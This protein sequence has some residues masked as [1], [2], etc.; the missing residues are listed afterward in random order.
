MSTYI[1]GI[2]AYFHDSSVALVKDGELIAAVE[3]ERFSRKKHDTSFPLDAIQY[4]LEEAGITIQEVTHIAF[5]EKPF[6]KMERIL[7]QHMEMFPYS[8]KSFYK[9]V[10]SWVNEKIRVQKTI[11]KELKFAGEIFYIPHHLCHAASS[12]LIS[13]YNESAILTIDGVGEWA[14]TTIGMAKGNEIKL[15]K[16][17]KFPHSI[18][19]L[20]STI[21]AFL[22]FKVN[23]G[24]YKAMGLSPYGNTTRKNPY[25]H[26]LK[27]V[28]KMFDDGSYQF[29][30]SYFVYHYATTMPSKKL[31]NLLGPARKPGTALTQRHKDIAAA[32]QMLTEELALNMLNALYKETGSDNLC[33]AGGCALNS[34]LNGKILNKT[35]FKNIYMQPAAGDA[36]TS[37]GAAFYA[38]NTILNNSRTFVQKTAFWGPSFTNKEVQH[39]LDKKKIVYT[40]FKNKKDKTETV[41]QL[42]HDSNVIGWF[43]GRME[44]GPR[45]LGSRSILSNPCD[46]KMQDILNLKVKHREKF[47]PFAP[48]ICADDAK[49]YFDCDLPL[50]KPTDFMLMVYPIKKKYH[51][52]IPAVTHV[53][54]SGRLQS[55]RKA[56]N[57]DYYNLI[58]AFGKKSKIP[59]L[60]NT[61]F[62]IR[63][64]PIVMK[65]DQA[66]RCMMGTGI[67]YLVIGDYLVKRSDNPKDIWDSEKHAKD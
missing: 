49:E 29:D 25:Y 38:Y 5:Y 33:V 45:A 13:P 39:F 7:S 51:K 62:N 12:Y 52:K 8:F 42:I 6:L 28:V 10:P 31:S 67:D 61:S 58:K 36:G 3:Q 50:P 40:R 30:M 4:C 64:E 37:I 66:Y 11:R 43:Q 41:A 46:P 17:I 34:V 44:W 19:L 18:G 47:R 48:V 16:Q 35:P 2:S 22:G 15:H 26:R 1:L 9:A 56:D 21:T 53:D 65:P 14:S 57:L 24:E 20:Y 55:I 63:G 59:I 60:I 27:R 32:N 54:G 23:N